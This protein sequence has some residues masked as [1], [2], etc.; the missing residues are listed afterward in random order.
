MPVALIAAPAAGGIRAHVAAVGSGHAVAV[1]PV[2]VVR[3]AC[4]HRARWHTYAQCMCP[5]AQQSPDPA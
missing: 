1:V 5:A 4:K 2:V 3:R